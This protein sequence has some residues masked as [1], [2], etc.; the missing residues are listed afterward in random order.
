MR[1]R[2]D[3]MRNRARRWPLR[4]HSEE[5][6]T[7]A[8]RR[9]RPEPVEGAR[10]P[11]GGQRA[12]LRGPLPLAMGASGCPSRPIAFW[13]GRLRMKA[14]GRARVAQEVIS[15]WIARNPLK[16][17]ESDEGIQENPSLFSWSRLVWLGFSLG[18]LGGGAALGSSNLTSLLQNP[19]NAANSLVRGGG[20]AG[21]QAGAGLSCVTRSI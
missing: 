15:I 14:S 13:N 9:A 6:K 16:S 19:S 1:P 8:S 17:P 10:A 21:A 11:A 4:L 20:A 2:S 3:L 5:P 7:Q 12:F 18:V